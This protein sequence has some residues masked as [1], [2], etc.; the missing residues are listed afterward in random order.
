MSGGDPRLRELFPF[1]GLKR[2]GGKPPEHLEAFSR[3]ERH[4]MMEKL[5]EL[6]LQRR[7][8]ELATKAENAFFSKHAD[9]YKEKYG[10]PRPQY[11]PTLAQQKAAKEVVKFSGVKGLTGELRYMGATGLGGEAAVAGGDVAEI[12]EESGH[13]FRKDVKKLHLV[14]QEARRRKDILRKISRLMRGASPLLALSL[15][16]PLLLGDDG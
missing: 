4:R 10:V 13:A 3:I 7:K 6:I 9:A 8:T 12:A 14:A 16:A 5:E 2:P 11:G 1:P 15:L